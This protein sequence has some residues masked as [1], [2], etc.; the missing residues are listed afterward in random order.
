MQ[1]IIDIINEILRE[2]NIDTHVDEYTPLYSSGLLSSF[3]VLNLLLQ[4]EKKGLKTSHI[5]SNS[6]DTATEIY[7][8]ISKD[9]R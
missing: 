7:G 4:L 9:I 8:Q 1:D 3:D 2:K 6:I 5:Q